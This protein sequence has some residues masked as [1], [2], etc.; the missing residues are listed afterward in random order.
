[1]NSYTVFQGIDQNKTLQI[2]QEVQYFAN[3]D[4]V[5]LSIAKAMYSV[6]PKCCT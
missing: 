1:M 3:N 4:Y 6:N 2:L 5:V